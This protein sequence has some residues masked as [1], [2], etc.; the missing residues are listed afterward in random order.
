MRMLTQKEVDGSPR[1]RVT[2]LFALIAGLAIM[3]LTSCGRDTGETVPDSDSLPIVRQQF[4]T[5][6]NLSGSDITQEYPEVFVYRADQIAFMNNE[7]PVAS[8]P[9]K[10]GCFEGT[11]MLDTT[12]V[13]DLVFTVPG[14][15]MAMVREFI[16]TS[17]GVSF[18]GPDS[19]DAEL[20]E[21]VSDSPENEG[22]KRFEAITFEMMPRISLV[23]DELG[24]LRRQGTLYSKAVNALLEEAETAESYSPEGLVVKRQ[25]DGLQAELDSLHI[26]YVEGHPSIGSLY[27][28]YSAI[29]YDRDNSD[30]AKAWVDLY[31]NSFADLFPDHPYHAMILSLTANQE[32]ERIRDFTLPDKHGVQHTLSELTAG[33]MAV[34]DF[35][36]SWCGSCRFRSKALI[37]VYEKYAGDDFTVVG[38]ALEYKN[39]AAWRKALAKDGYPWTNLIA[40]DAAPTLMA[41]HSKVFLLDRNGTILAIDPTPADLDTILQTQL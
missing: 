11:V 13:Y 23:Y 10:E 2:I 38:V 39:D 20:I 40:I 1:S 25:L 6:C 31:D 30:K 32:G 36:A 15:G 26:A 34:V 35:W 5:Q 22:L 18:I 4:V 17:A 28:I 12:L 37:P 29:N 24:R 27:R 19:M 8:F 21:L 16:P 7:Q 41:N 33:K 14:S 9:V 3:C